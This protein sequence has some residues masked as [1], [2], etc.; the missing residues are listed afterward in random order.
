MLSHSGTEAKGSDMTLVSWS[1]T[2][3]SKMK[4]KCLNIWPSTN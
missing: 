2:E 3:Y 1:E 4:D